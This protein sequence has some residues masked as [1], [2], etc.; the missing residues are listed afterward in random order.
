MVNK[1]IIFFIILGSLSSCIESQ[2]QFSKIPPGMWRGVLYLN[3][4]AQVNA[5]D[6]KAITTNPD[7]SEQLPFNFEVIYDTP[8]DFHIVIHNADER[9]KVDN[10]LYG[11]DAT[12]AKDT[13]QIQFLEYDT[14]ISAVYEEKVMEGFWHINYKDNY[15][16]KFKAVH[17]DTIR[18][19]KGITTP[20]IDIAGKW[21]VMFENGTE[22]EYPAIGTFQQN[23][24]YLTGT[25][26]TETGDYR[27]LEGKVA[28]NK[29]FLSCFDGAHAFLFEGKDLG[30]GQLNG[31]FKSGISYTA[32]FIAV[33]NQGKSL[34]DPFTLTK[35]TTDEPIMLSFPNSDGKMVSL[36]DPQYKGKTKIID[37]MGTWCPNCKDA[38]NFLKEFKKSPEGQDVV[39]IGLAFERYK[40]EAKNLAQIKKYKEK[41]QT[42]WEI[43]LGGYYAK[44]EAA[45]AIP[46]IDQIMSY[47]TMLF[48]DKDNRIK[49]IH[50]GFSGPATAEYENFKTKFNTIINDL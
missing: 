34:A 40:D 30:D 27:Y 1:F 16:V 25:F 5:V 21:D 48:L 39:V 18:F 17:G 37:I 7:N 46:Q 35:A 45:K 42:P 49:Y 14:R 44:S 47:P 22:S 9:I 36:N 41:S 29:V 11:R 15:A 20:D 8:D 13:L 19:D 32:P 2:N 4:N 10:I 38:S 28:G 23:G 12:T 33:K 50:T 31:I 6:K 3:P 26:E 24:S 43:L